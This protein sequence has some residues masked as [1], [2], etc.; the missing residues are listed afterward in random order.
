MNLKWF[1]SVNSFSRP[2]AGSKN[3]FYFHFPLFLDIEK[4]SLNVINYTV[5]LSNTITS[6]VRLKLAKNQANAK[7]HRVTEILLF[8]NYLLSSSTLSSKNNRIYSKK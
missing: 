7:Q 5:F 8:E 4:K 1:Y 6:N 3:C 2:R